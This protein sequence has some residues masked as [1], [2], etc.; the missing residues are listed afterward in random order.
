MSRRA[1][2]AGRVG[3]YASG[4]GGGVLTVGH[5]AYAGV[6]TRLALAPGAGIAAAC[7]S[8]TVSL[9]PCMS[10]TN[11]MSSATTKQLMCR[12]FPHAA[13]MYAVVPWRQ[14]SHDWRVDHFTGLCTALGCTAGNPTF[15]K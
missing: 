14:W 7:T 1:G 3:R 10:M 2:H 4:G 11:Y 8:T 15:A 6:P 9:I 12:C 5:A 13:Q